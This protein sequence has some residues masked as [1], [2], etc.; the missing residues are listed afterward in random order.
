MGAKTSADKRKRVA[1]KQTTRV[2][3]EG[4]GGASRHAVHVKTVA[5]LGIIFSCGSSAI[6]NYLAAGAPKKEAEGYDVRKWVAWWCDYKFGGA[7]AQ[8]RAER[9]KASERL[10]LAKA[11]NEELKFE[12]AERTVIDRAEAEQRV[13]DV[14]AW[15]VSNME[16]AAVELPARLA[17]RTVAAQKKL[18]KAYFDAIRLAAAGRKKEVDS[19]EGRDA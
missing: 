17:G 13:V 8:Q 4:R 16:Q 11:K 14:L 3:R 1:A 12:R 19:A 18:I 2:A 15:T 7:P 6:H 9:R 10:T 5:E